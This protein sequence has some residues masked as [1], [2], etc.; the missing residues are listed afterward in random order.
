MGRKDKGSARYVLRIPTATGKATVEARVPRGPMRLSELVPLA[1]RFTDVAVEQSIQLEA[2]EGR[3]L[4]CSKGC[5]ACCHQ[6]VPISAPEAFRLADAIIDLPARHRDAV[7]SRFDAAE[8]ELE[9]RGML[10]K[11]DLLIQSG[12]EG[13]SLGALA[14]DYFS[15]HLACPVLQDG[16]ECGVRADRPLS[17]RDYNVS[18]PAAWCSSPGLYKIRKIPTPPLLS[19]PLAR[20]AARLTG[21]GVQLIPLCIAM[22]WVDQNAELGM[23]TWPGTELFTGWLAEMGIQDAVPE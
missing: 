13:Q 11:L 23:R 19:Q 1:Q 6:I 15:L 7:L 12:G 9:A 20:L 3:P 8:S 14:A 17:C 2:R 10:A 4:S 5:A 22:R 16:A 21:S 18:S